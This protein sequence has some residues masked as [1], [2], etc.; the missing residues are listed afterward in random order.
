MTNHKFYKDWEYIENINDLYDT[1]RSPPFGVYFPYT[2]TKNVQ[3]VEVKTT[4]IRNF[5]EDIL[6][7]QSSLLKVC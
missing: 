6:S 1:K 4:K 3:N 5:N 2:K 7:L